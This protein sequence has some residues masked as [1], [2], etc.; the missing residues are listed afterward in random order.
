MQDSSYHILMRRQFRGEKLS[1]LE[2]QKLTEYTETCLRS[3]AD[4]LTVTKQNE[5]KEN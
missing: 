5:S 3:I 2:K 4:G 1:D